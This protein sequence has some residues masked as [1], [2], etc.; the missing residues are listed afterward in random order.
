MSFKDR[1]FTYRLNAMGDQA[2]GAFEQWCADNEQNYIRWGLDRPP[3][4]LRMIPTRLRYAP[5]YLM[6]N[7]FVECQGFGADQTFKLK[8]EKHGALHWWNDLHP[9]E[10]WVLDSHNQR[11]CLLTLREFDNVLGTA[12]AELRSF[13]EGKTYFAV[14]GDAIFN[15]AEGRTY[16]TEA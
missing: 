12:G 1:D 3:L 16:A 4:N 6:S 2:E 13:P 9:V 15:A 14:A 8:V 7:K 11:A 5:D 10:L